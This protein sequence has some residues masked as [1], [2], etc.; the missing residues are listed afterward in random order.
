MHQIPP[1]QKIRRNFPSMLRAGRKLRGYTQHDIAKLLSTS[2]SRISNLESGLTVPDAAEWIYLCENL[3][4]PAD[5]AQK[6]YLDWASEVQITNERRVGLFRLPKRYANLQASKVRTARVFLT[7][8]N[9]LL[10]ES[11]FQSFLSEAGIDIDYFR[12]LDQQ[13]NIQLTYDIANEIEKRNLLNEHLADFM[14]K[15]FISKSTQGNALP[16]NN[17]AHAPITR[18]VQLI[19]NISRYEQ[20]NEYS[21]VDRNE[22]SA[23]ISTH[24]TE[25]TSEFSA[26]PA[27]HRFLCLYKKIAFKK[28]LEKSSAPSQAIFLDEIECTYTGSKRCLFRISIATPNH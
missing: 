16:H 8:F 6:G 24:P 22:A 25:L 4:L 26:S 13:V 3:K 21:I 28:F 27:A 9:W 5:C 23:L 17:T 11:A 19:K 14:A 2:Q 18:L 7:T 12:I 15:K 20:N 1:I 10:G